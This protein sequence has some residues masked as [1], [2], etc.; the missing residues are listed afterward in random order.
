[1][2]TVMPVSRPCRTASRRSRGPTGLTRS[3]SLGLPTLLA[4]AV[5][6]VAV[7]ACGSDTAPGDDAP[8][9]GGTQVGS[10]GLGHLLTD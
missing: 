8:S 2:S 4:L 10:T 1:M 5:V 3:R 7:V 6:L 9:G